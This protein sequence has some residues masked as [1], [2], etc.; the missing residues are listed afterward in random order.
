MDGRIVSKLDNKLEIESLFFPFI[1]FVVIISELIKSSSF[2]TIRN[3]L[4]GNI[5]LCVA[6]GLL[7]LFP[8]VKLIKQFFSEIKA[9]VPDRRTFYIR[10]FFLI[11]MVIYHINAVVALLRGIADIGMILGVML[12]D[13]IICVSLYLYMNKK[14]SLLE[15][16]KITSLIIAITA[17]YGIV[18]Y[19][20]RDSITPLTISKTGNEPR[21][22]S[23]YQHPVTA[24]GVF[25]IGFWL[26]SPRYKFDKANVIGWLIRI[27]DAVAIIFTKTRNA[28]MGLF[29]SG[30]I[31][32]V[33]IVFSKFKNP[34]K[35]MI[36]ILFICISVATIVCIIFFN[37]DYNEFLLKFMR[38][39]NFGKSLS[40]T[41]R[42][43]RIEYIFKYFIKDA[44]ILTW[45][46]GNGCSS[47]LHWV[48][49][50]IPE[51]FR[52]ALRSTD[53]QFLLTWYEAGIIGLIFNAIIIIAIIA[54]IKNMY[55]IMKA[56][57]ANIKENYL[58][59]S[60]SCVCVSMIIP[61]F[62]YDIQWQP[63][64]LIIFIPMIVVVVEQ[65]IRRDFKVDA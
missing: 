20:L 16:L 25:L 11:A 50:Y 4:I 7:S 40:V 34:V 47:I 39:E 1:M 56:F 35:V 22:Y 3:P 26:P 43:N 53:N 32:L 15:G 19:I 37:S 17:I 62:F 14:N 57:T 23:I 5:L 58:Y 12:N 24:S 51:E 13:C 48:D 30:F 64:I 45:I 63:D 6:V 44:S 65:F 18:A 42:M 29:L 59:I 10:L 55:R 41:V 36:R 2:D 60:A 38:M 21:L 33:F 46:F 49:T 61:A 9:L 52:I 31:Y 27:V 8:I 28:W 54:G